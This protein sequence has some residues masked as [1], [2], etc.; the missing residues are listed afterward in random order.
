MV[1]CFSL[2]QGWRVRCCQWKGKFSLI[3]SW[4]GSKGRTNLRI[5]TVILTSYSF[6]FRIE[7]TIERKFPSAELWFPSWTALARER[8]GGGT[9]GTP[10]NGLDQR[11]IE[12]K[13]IPQLSLGEYGFVV[14]TVSRAGS[15]SV[16]G[17]QIGW[18]GWFM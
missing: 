18:G 2:S 13:R 17:G 12:K 11:F 9:S 16:V 14:A 15:L 5:L 1:P 4:Y 8:H 3:R 10:R 7:V 6:L